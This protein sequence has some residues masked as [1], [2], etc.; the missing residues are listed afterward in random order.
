MRS[1]T[2]GRYSRSSETVCVG[3]ARTDGTVV[4]GKRKVCGE[5]WHQRKDRGDRGNGV[6]NKGKTHLQQVH[7]VRLHAVDSLTYG[8]LY[9]WPGHFH[10]SKYTPL[11]RA[12]DLDRSCDILDSSTLTTVKKKKKDG[13]RGE[14]E[15]SSVRS[16][17]ER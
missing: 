6:R 16:D 10:R 12:N 8:F 14:G 3:T 13:T 1:S 17:P 15:N 2:R 11:C 7:S 9:D 4:R 5:T